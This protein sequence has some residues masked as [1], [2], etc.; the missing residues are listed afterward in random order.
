M[1]FCPSCNLHIEE[2]FNFCPN[3]GTSLEENQGSEIIEG[4]AIEQLICN[5][6]GEENEIDASFCVSCGANLKSGK[7]EIRETTKVISKPVLKVPDLKVEKQR[8]KF[9]QKKQHPKNKKFQKETVSNSDQPKRSAEFDTKKIATVFS[10]ILLLALI[11]LYFAGVF[12]EPKISS[13][14][15]QPVNQTQGSGIDLASIDRINQLDAHLKSEPNNFELILQ[16]AHLKNDSGFKEDAIKLYQKYLEKFPD[17]TDVLVDMGVCYFD[18]KNYDEAIP[19]M[20][21]AIKINPKHQIAN[22]NLGIV[23][24]AKGNIEKSK[25]W[26]Q[27]AVA[28]DPNSEIGRKAKELLTSH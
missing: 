28:L 1:R 18:L 12:D 20:E 5:S 21:K 23:N 4:T 15:F 25:E 8:E 6:C 22:M 10:V 27:K 13:E 26:L 14:N 19:A 16:L 9:N 3:C 17:N 11:I 7:V 2:K 24:L